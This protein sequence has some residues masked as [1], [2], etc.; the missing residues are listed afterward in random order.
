MFEDLFVITGSIIY[1]A[2]ILIAYAIF[3]ITQKQH[4]MYLAMPISIFWPVVIV[5]L[6]VRAPFFIID[7]IKAHS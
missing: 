6:I 5:A 7:K 2:G 3:S 1:F 4:S